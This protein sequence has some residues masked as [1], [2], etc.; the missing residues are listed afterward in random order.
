MASLPHIIAKS[1]D[2]LNP[3][4]NVA[5]L[6]RGIAGF[7]DYY[8]NRRSHQGIGHKIPAPVSPARSWVTTAS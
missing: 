1:F 4:D 6:R 5:S 7:I 2:F 3:E 8:N